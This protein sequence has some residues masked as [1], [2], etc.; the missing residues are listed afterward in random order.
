MTLPQHA[1]QTGLICAAF[2][3]LRKW[4]IILA[5]EIL[6]VAPDIG[7]LFQQ[8]PDDWTKFYQWAHS[9]WYCFFIPFWN[10]HI[11]EDHF[12][13]QPGGGWYWWAYYLEVLLWISEGILISFLYQRKVNRLKL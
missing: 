7:R 6:T 9:S 8:N 11:L 5:A 13:H 12:I 10:L 3:Q 4:Y 2:P 1:V